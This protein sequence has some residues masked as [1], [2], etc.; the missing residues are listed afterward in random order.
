MSKYVAKKI[1]NDLKLI[2]PKKKKIHFGATFKENCS[3]LR[4][5]KFLT[6]LSF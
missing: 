1:L 6:P 5:Q 3:D 4:I 2:K